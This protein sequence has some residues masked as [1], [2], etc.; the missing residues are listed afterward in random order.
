[1][2]WI[3][4]PSEDSEKIS[5]EE[6]DKKQQMKIMASDKEWCRCEKVETK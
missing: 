5:A 2:D 4:L 3:R 6:T 1:M